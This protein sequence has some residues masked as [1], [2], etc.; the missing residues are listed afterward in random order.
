MSP[1]GQYRPGAQDDEGVR[2]GMDAASVA[3]AAGLSGRA[4][5]GMSK[6]TLAALGRMPK[7]AQQA[8][9]AEIG[10]A[11]AQ[12]AAEWSPALA[13]RVIATYLDSPTYYR[14]T[15]K[16]DTL[17]TG[18]IPQHEMHQKYAGGIFL[19]PSKESAKGYGSK[20]YVWW[21][22]KPQLG[23]NGVVYSFKVDGDI[24]D[25][26][27]AYDPN[28]HVGVKLNN[29]E[30]IIFKRD[31][32]VPADKKTAKHLPDLMRKEG[33]SL[34]ADNETA[35]APVAAVNEIARQHLGR[36]TGEQVASGGRPSS[37]EALTA[38]AVKRPTK[39]IATPIKAFHGSPHDFD[40]FDASKIGTGEGAQ[41]Y[42][43]G[44]YFAE[45]EG[46][47][48]SYRDT[49]ASKRASV[50]GPGSSAEH[51][52]A[53]KLMEMT[54]GP[55]KGAAYESRDI[56]SVLQSLDKFAPAMRES[57]VDPGKVRAVLE[58]G[59]LSYAPGKMYEVALHAEPQQ[60]LDWDTPLSQQGKSGADAVRAH[61]ALREADH[62]RRMRPL[63]GDAFD[64]SQTGQELVRSAQDYGRGVDFTNR[65]RE[66][67]IPGIR[68]K[69]QLS[70]GKEGGSYNYVVFPG[71]ED[72]IEI[73]GK[74]GKPLKGAEK[75]KAVKELYALQGMPLPDDQE[76]QKPRKGKKSSS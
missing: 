72:L 34:L 4:F 23:K 55:P 1:E 45:S 43:Y 24:A 5:A 47:A 59:E 53:R 33:P 8:A 36:E 76:K 6:E 12:N 16:R 71:A 10:Q 39:R 19:T 15:V 9:T 65:L 51:D 13:D 67:G 54:V 21:S 66:A 62:A 52:A 58:S 35:S 38:E 20:E 32:L 49:L 60:F 70:R 42:G 50:N 63:E 73:I 2:L 3:V 48:K 27:A 40:R 29:A 68:Y 75:A 7:E 30:T 26:W 41:A 74:D 28:T 57:G 37:R 17:H 64:V 11:Y 44:L 46:T 14:G 22:D 69:D 61:E 18:F 56:E 31:A 25:G